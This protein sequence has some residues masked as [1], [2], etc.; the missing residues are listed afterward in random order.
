M[1][2]QTPAHYQTG[3]LSAALLVLQ[4]LHQIALELFGNIQQGAC[5]LVI[6]N[7]KLVIH[8]GNPMDLNV[9][10]SMDIAIGDTLCSLVQ[11]L[12]SLCLQLLASS[13]L[14]HLLQHPFDVG[15]GILVQLTLVVVVIFDR[16]SNGS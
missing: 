2:I 1:C 15:C 10:A 13:L 14:S 12:E 4:F 11:F 5:N 8:L 9:H 7:L 16:T 3:L 6:L